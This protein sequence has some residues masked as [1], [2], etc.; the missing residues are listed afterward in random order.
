MKKAYNLRSKNQTKFL[1]SSICI[2]LFIIT[3]F[4]GC[5]T[6]SVSERKNVY[7]IIPAPFSIKEKPGNFVF[8]KDS[9]IILSAI[10]EENRFAADFLSSLIKNPTGIQIPIVEGTRG[11]PG[12]VYMMIDSSIVDNEGYTLIINPKKMVIKA[13]K[14]FPAI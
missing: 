9:K 1:K 6:G 8:N 7:A 12:S 14:R 5:N 11:L 13:K 3:L 4:T 2:V 10:N